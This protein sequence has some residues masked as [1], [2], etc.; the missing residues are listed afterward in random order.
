MYGIY[1]SPLDVLVIPV[2]ESPTPVVQYKIYLFLS[3]HVDK[4]RC[5]KLLDPIYKYWIC[6]TE[7]PYNVFDVKEDTIWKALVTAYKEKKDGLTIEEI[8]H[9]VRKACA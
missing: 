1:N 6:P 5:Q 4:K 8:F 3:T 2:Q 9:I 7:I